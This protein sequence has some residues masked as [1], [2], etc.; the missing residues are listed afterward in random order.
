[1]AQP[2]PIPDWFTDQFLEKH[3]QNHYNNTNIRVIDFVVKPSSNDGNFASKIYRVFV[4]FS[5]TPS[6]NEQTKNGVSFQNDIFS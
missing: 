6:N 4:Q 5:T 3:L 2:S 1:M